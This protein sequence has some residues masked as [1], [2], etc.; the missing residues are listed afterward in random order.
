MKKRGLFSKWFILPA[1]VAAM[2][3]SLALGFTQASFNDIETSSAST[4]AAWA[5]TGWNQTS[6]TDFNNAF[7]PRELIELLSDK[8]REQEA[9]AMLLGKRI[10]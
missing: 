3:A 1:V 8:K 5:S 6:Q 2:L 9:L 4:A 7:D 10:K